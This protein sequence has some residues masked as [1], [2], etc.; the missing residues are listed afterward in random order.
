MA[1]DAVETQ[2]GVAAPNSTGRTS[3]VISGWAY[4]SEG[5]ERGKGKSKEG[6]WEEEGCR[7]EEEEEEEEENIGVSPTTPERGT[8]EGSYPFGEH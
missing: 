1:R 4:S 6:S 8:R 3:K 7:E 2:G 5:K